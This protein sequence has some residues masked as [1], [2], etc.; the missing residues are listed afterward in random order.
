MD[1]DVM[2]FRF[3]IEFSHLKPFLRPKLNQSTPVLCIL[4][5]LISLKTRSGWVEGIKKIVRCF[6]DTVMAF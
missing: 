5:R 6:Y 4:L 2:L 3:V 1:M